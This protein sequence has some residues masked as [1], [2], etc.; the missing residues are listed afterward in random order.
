MVTFKFNRQLLYGRSKLDSGV[1]T[2]CI[3]MRNWKLST[4]HPPGRT[5]GTEFM[6]PT[7]FWDFVF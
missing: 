2:S 6:G 1:I 4:D 5:L 7:V 3:Y